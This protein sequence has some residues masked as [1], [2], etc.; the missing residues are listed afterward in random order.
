MAES[1]HRNP[2]LLAAFGVFL[3]SAGQL[4]DT[5]RD[6]RLSKMFPSQRVARGMPPG[7]VREWA[8]AVAEKIGQAWRVVGSK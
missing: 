1:G 5:E 6:D 7:H 3:A 8:T 4:A 2:I